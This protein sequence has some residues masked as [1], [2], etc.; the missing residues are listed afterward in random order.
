MIYPSEVTVE[1]GQCGNKSIYRN[2]GKHSQRIVTWKAI[3]DGWYL[4]IEGKHLCPECR[5]KLEKQTGMPEHI[6]TQGHEATAEK[7]GAMP[8]LPIKEGMV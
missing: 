5:Q 3:L 7:I 6:N 2:P 8:Q 1:C 4:P